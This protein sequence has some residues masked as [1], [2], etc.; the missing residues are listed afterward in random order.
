MKNISRFMSILLCLLLGASMVSC[1]KPDISDPLAENPELIQNV[2]NDWMPVLSEEECLKTMGLGNSED[3]LHVAT[4][5]RSRNYGNFLYFLG[6]NTYKNKTGK[7][8]S[9]RMLMRYDLRTAQSYPACA[10]SACL[11]RDEGCPF[12]NISVS[13]FV[14]EGNMVYMLTAASTDD[15]NV[16]TSKKGGICSYNLDTLEYEW[17]CDREV[18]AL[19][20]LGYY[21]NKLYYV[22]HEYKKDNNEHDKYVWECNIKTEKTKKL[23]CYGDE[24]DRGKEGRIP[25]MIDEKG[26]ML[27][28]NFISMDSTAVYQESTVAF[29]YAELEKDAEVKKIVEHNARFDWLSHQTLQYHDGKLYFSE[30]AERSEEIA[31][32]VN[33]KEYSTSTVRHAICYVDINTGEIGTLIENTICGFAIAGDYV[34]YI[35]YAPE[36]IEYENGDSLVAKANGSVMQYN[37]KTGQE[38]EFKINGRLDLGHAYTYYYRGRLFTYAYD[39]KDSSD[40]RGAEIE[41]D[42]ITGEYRKIPKILLQAM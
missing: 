25:L 19:S 9:K 15:G 8:V 7:E 32:T 26:R 41:I 23:F 5:V 37:L 13:G 18:S 10:D 4:H 31:Y 21:Q 34:Y 27:F 29:E 3:T 28:I 16:D 20:Y 2:T 12:Y 36:V 1:A 6:Y 38:K 42:L 17:I 22:Q 39:L 33:G 14:M 24:K 11:H 30:F 40:A 35:P